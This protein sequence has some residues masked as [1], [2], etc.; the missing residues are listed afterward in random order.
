MTRI[1]PGETGTGPGP[2]S[3]ASDATG[4]RCSSS[5]PWWRQA[6]WPPR[7][8]RAPRPTGARTPRR[9]HPS[10]WP[11]S[12]PTRDCR[13]RTRWPRRRERPPTTTGHP[14]CDFKTG[15]LSI[16]TIYAPPCVPVTRGGN[17]GATA[18]GVTGTTITLAYYVPPPGDLASLAEGAAGNPASNLLTAENYAAML[19]HITPLYGR[20]VQVVPL[21]AS[22]TSTDAVAARADAIRVAEQIHAFAS[23][24]GPAE[25]PVYQDELARMHVLCLSCGVGAPYSEVQQDAPYLWS[26]LPRATRC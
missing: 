17:G 5:P 9:G 14:G 20:Q 12:A 26:S 22:G 8:P 18:A 10:T 1:P 6:P 13:S 16:P 11:T 7:G 24:G 15:R 4:P 23:I 3:V 19:N 2:A 21:D 25:T